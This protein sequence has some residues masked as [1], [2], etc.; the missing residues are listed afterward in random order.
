MNLTG[1]SV[2]LL[3]L[4]LSLFVLS[5]CEQERNT[6][7]AVRE[8]AVEE[9][10]LQPEYAKLDV[11]VEELADNLRVIYGNGPNSNVGL[12]YGEDGALLI[13]TQ[14]EPMSDKLLAIIRD[15]TDAP[16]RY[17]INTHVHRDHLQGNARL[18]SE[19]TTII[20]HNNLYQRLVASGADT[21]A[22]MLPIM[23]YDDTASVYL[24][25]EKITISWPGPAHTDGDSLV[26]FHGANVVFTGDLFFR[27]RFPFIDRANG[28]SLAG[29][30][31]HTDRLIDLADEKTIFVPGHHQTGSRDD[32][33]MFRDMLIR[34]RDEIAA[35]AD[36]EKTVDEIIAAR[37]F[38]DLYDEWQTPFMPAER[39]IRIL[40]EEL[41]K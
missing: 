26:R 33:V 28:G 38:A 22:G 12:F 3:M 14:L 5:A 1:I 32:L 8:V 24:N 11:R 35:L 27:H 34:T 10:D 18:G 37:P 21:P 31:S 2:K 20:G 39:Y 29:L 15:I 23:T 13:D 4:L 16:I 17:I 41:R 40:F 19:D 25:G 36:R 6:Q 9:P 30:I 7:Q